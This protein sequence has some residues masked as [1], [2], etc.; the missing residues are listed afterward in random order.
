VTGKCEAC[1]EK[2]Y[3]EKAHIYAAGWRR[4]GGCGCKVNIVLLCWR[5]HRQLMHG[6]NGGWSGLMATLTPERLMFFQLRMNQAQA[7]YYKRLRGE[8]MRCNRNS[9]LADAA[10]RRIAAAEGVTTT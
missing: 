1:G 10:R 6:V 5:C 8:P 4:K 9:K 7:H 3:V 2:G